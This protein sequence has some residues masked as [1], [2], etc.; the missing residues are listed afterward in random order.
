MYVCMYYMYMHTCTSLLL[1]SAAILHDDGAIYP[2]TVEV[3]S[4]GYSVEAI[5][6]GVAGGRQSTDL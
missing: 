4:K 6:V 3:T 1:Q 2:N 5:E